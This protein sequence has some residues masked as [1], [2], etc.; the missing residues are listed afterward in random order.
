VISDSDN[1]VVATINVAQY[2]SDIPGP[3]GMPEGM[4]YDSGKGEIFVANGGAYAVSV[5]SDSNSSVVA[6]IG[7]VNLPLGSSVTYDS[8]KGELFVTGNPFSVISDSNNSV[9]LFTMT[10][11]GL[12][13]QV[14]TTS[15]ATT[16]QALL[17]ATPL[18]L[19]V[20]SDYFFPVIVIVAIVPIVVVAVTRR[21]R[22]VQ[23]TAPAMVQTAQPLSKEMIDNLERLAALYAQGSLT[24]EEYDAL[25]TKARAPAAEVPA[26]T[27]PVP[28]GKLTK[29]RKHAIVAAV[30]S[31]FI[32]GVGQI[33]VGRLARGIALFFL[34]SLLLAIY[35]GIGI[36]N[37]LAQSVT[38]AIGGAFTLGQSLIPPWI[39]Q[40]L[41]LAFV[42]AW[43]LQIV[44]AYL[45]AKRYNK[46]V[47]QTGRAP[48]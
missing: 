41:E 38:S 24:K 43:L 18:S 36:L 26:W 30:L 47:T 34:V 40:G 11:T 15:T 16:S 13:K 27:G 45:K 25:K 8:G 48:W 22:P 4:A 9:A 12:V 39:Q 42:L 2:S 28:T 14:P 21:K 3:V 1:S 7:V 10:P 29:K 19:V 23:V 46:V 35:I 17:I 32:P 5:I 20:S 33:Y 31:F 37:D 6:T 44:D